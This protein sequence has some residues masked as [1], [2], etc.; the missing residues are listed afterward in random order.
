MKLPELQELQELVRGLRAELCTPIRSE[1]VHTKRACDFV[2]EKDLFV[3]QYLKAELGR[4]Y[5]HIAFHGEEGDNER[6]DPARPCFVLDPIDGTTNFIF[7]Y[8]LSAVSLAVVLQGAPILAV[9]YNP[10]T[11]EL[12]AA[13]RG[14]GA[15][16]N[17]RPIRAL[18]ATELS[19]VL[20]AVGTMPYQKER[21]DE[22]F[23]L[24]KR[25]YLSCLDVRRSGA[26]S[27]DL[28]HTACGRIGVYFERALS[29]WDFAAG[30]LILTEAGGVISDWSGKPLSFDGKSD[31]AAAAPHLHEKLLDM[32]NQPL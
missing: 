29:L 31:I 30:A 17:G 16:C 1:D 24:A 19:Q 18:A 26:A 13:E 20:A 3:E 32:L 21:A 28:C 15:T 4:R 2:T 14:K 11:D 25:A 5:A 12:F 22:L 23:A 10:H 6:I 8:G 9:V 27:I 7:G